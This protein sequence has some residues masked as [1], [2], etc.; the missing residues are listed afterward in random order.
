MQG[1][2]SW[3]QNAR[4]SCY[5]VI[6]SWHFIS[7]IN[8]HCNF[9]HLLVIKQTAEP[10]SLSFA[11]ARARSFFCTCQTLLLSWSLDEIS[12]EHKASNLKYACEKGCVSSKQRNLWEHTQ[13]QMLSIA[14]LRM[15]ITS[16]FL[17]IIASNDEHHCKEKSFTRVRVG[18]HVSVNEYFSLVRCS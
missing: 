3:T 13:L 6:H 7:L 2:R 12:S 8:H 10:F 18:T 9:S 5:V 17:Y 1:S 4:K 16:D 15:S 11:D 14:H